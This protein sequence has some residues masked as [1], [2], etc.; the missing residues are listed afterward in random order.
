MRSKTNTRR[1][2]QCY[3]KDTQKTSLFAEIIQ[4]IPKMEPVLA[5]VDGYLQDDELFQLIGLI[6]RSGNGQTLGDRAQLDAGV[7]VVL[8]M[9]V[10]KRL[11][12]YSYEE[13]ERY[14][15]DSLVLRQF[16]RVYLN[17]AAR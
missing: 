17:R 12:G 6:Y 11:Y 13:T 2:L 15:R 4:L 10:V 9:P 8:R 1:L 5:K 3:V 7:E 16:C 14:V